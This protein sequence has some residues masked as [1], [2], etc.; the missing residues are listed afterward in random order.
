MKLRIYCYEH[1]REVKA[2]P[3][4]YGIQ[5]LSACP[6]CI[7]EAYEKGKADALEEAEVHA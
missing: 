4:T 2:E 6:A 3:S 7:E 1:D 5:L